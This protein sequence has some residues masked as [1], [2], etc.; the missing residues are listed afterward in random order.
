M[1]QVILFKKLL[2]QKEA[3]NPIWKRLLIASVIIHLQYKI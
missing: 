2:T 3:Y 1:I